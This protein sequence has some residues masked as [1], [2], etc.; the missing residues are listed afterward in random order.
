MTRGSPESMEPGALRRFVLPIGFLVLLFWALFTRR[1]EPAPE[2]LEISGPTMGTQY[3]I[4]IVEAGLD[5]PGQQALGAAIEETLVAVNASMST[6]LPDSEI[7]RFNAL[8][9]T[10]PFAISAD[11]AAVLVESQAISE[12]S[13]GAFDATVGP[14]VNLWGFGPEDAPSEVSDE[15]LETQR[16]RVGYQHLS[17][18]EGS[19]SKSVANQVVDLSA[20]A[21]GWGVDR[22]V[23]LLEE[24]GH[25]N[26]MAEIGGEVSA[27]GTNHKGG[28]WRL[29]IEKP[30]MEGRKVHTVV[31]LSD[32]AMATSGDYRNFIGEGADRRSHTIDPRT[33]RPVTHSLASVSVVAESCMEADGWAT[34]LTVLGP[35][36][37]LQK[38][39]EEGLAAFFLVR[40]S[41]GSFTE[42]A[43]TAFSG[44]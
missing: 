36:E 4:L 33:G 27:R 15:A 17:V 20:I 3:R 1:P 2:V 41:D 19:L 7:S 5:G 6:Y 32:M 25:Q 43:T 10:E 37:G 12:A 14:L 11:F 22:L 24:R 26:F 34:A 13:G 40:E 31:E 8:E 16:A 44:L 29:G 23:A 39:E 35:E 18:G 30:L 21:K 38:A 42:S 28:A 9:S